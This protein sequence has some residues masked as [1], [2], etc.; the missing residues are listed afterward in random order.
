MPARSLL[1]SCVLLAGL[2]AG[3]ATSPGHLS[4]A[5]QKH[6]TQAIAVLEHRSD[7]DSLAAR[8]LA[9]RFIQ[10]KPD[11]VLPL[12]VRAAALEPRRADLTWLEIESCQQAP[13][14]DAG[15]AEARLR[16]LDP[17]NGA[18]WIGAL[19]RADAAG[20]DA[21]SVAALAQ[22]AKSQRI[23]T[24]WTTLIAHLTRTLASTGKIAAP[25]AL[26][27]VIGV[28]SVQSV[29]GYYAIAHLCFGERLADTA[30][31]DDCRRVAASLQA[32]DTYITAMMGAAIAQRVWPVESGQW[33]AAAEAR[34][35]YQYRAQAWVP[36]EKKWLHDPHWV[37]SFLLLCEQKRS[38]QEV[39]G[40]ELEQQGKPPYP[41]PDWTPSRH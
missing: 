34:R 30:L 29:P 10:P 16:A 24:F 20:D 19:S 14:C 17:S 4:P 28:L 26:T 35:V 22:L 3:C 18:G 27:D 5:D 36:S 33:K 37:A 7:A 15:A 21:A 32:G 2:S 23:D 31:L 6:L 13:G 38:E 8:A 12:L 39:Y 9:L 1:V 40:A 11:L 25:E 41:P